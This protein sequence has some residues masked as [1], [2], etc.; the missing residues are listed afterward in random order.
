MQVTNN[1]IRDAQN[2]INMHVLKTPV[3][4]NSE[5]NKN[6]KSLVLSKGQ[7]AQI[8][9]KNAEIIQKT[10]ANILSIIGVIPNLDNL[11]PIL[12]VIGS[13]LLLIFSNKIN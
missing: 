13:T 6:N 4:S 12:F 3:K 1:T 5:I 7:R 9:S 2:R 10:I 8:E 11:R